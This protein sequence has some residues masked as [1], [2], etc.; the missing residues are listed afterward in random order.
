MPELAAPTNARIV[1]EAD[2]SGDF[3]PELWREKNQSAMLSRASKLRNRRCSV[4]RAALGPL[5]QPVN[6]PKTRG[7]AARK[8]R[9]S[10]K[11]ARKPLGFEQYFCALVPRVVEHVDKRHAYDKCKDPPYPEQ[12][13][14]PRNLGAVKIVGDRVGAQGKEVWTLNRV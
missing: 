2:L 10:S 6:R 12:K 13:P 7:P 11:R 4:V 5:H 14:S 9:W 3:G 1:L 8:S